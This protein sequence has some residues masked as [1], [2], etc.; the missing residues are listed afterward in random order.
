MTGMALT[1]WL[2]HAIFRKIFWTFAS[3]FI[4]VVLVGAWFN[5]AGWLISEFHLDAIPG[6]SAFAIDFHAEMTK[7]IATVQR[8]LQQLH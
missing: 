3:F 1:L 2:I 8:I 4:G 7:A 5:G 6:F